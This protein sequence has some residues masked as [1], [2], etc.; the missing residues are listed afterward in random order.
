ME[1]RRELVV[2]GGGPGGDVA[3]LRAARLGLGVTLIDERENLGGTCLNIGCIPS[4]ALLDLSEHYHLAKNGFEKMGIRTGGVEADLGA[5]MRWKQEVVKRSTQGV[6]YLFKKAGIEVVRGRGRLAGPGLVELVGASPAK[7][8]AKHVLLAPGSIP[9]AVP[10]LPTDGRQILTSTEALALEAVPASMLVIG[11]G[12]I[13]LELGSVWARLGTKVTVVEMLDSLLPTL[14]RELGSAL[15]R[16]LK[17]LG[18]TFHLSTTIT[19]LAER[20]DSGV[21]LEANG[22]QGEQVRLEAE[23]V[24][25]AVGRRPNTADLGLAETGVLT[26]PAGRIVIDE[27]WQT[28]VPGIYA[29]GDAVAG[30]MLA[31][32][33]SEEGVAVAETIAG[34]VGHVNYTTL[35][36]VVYTWPEV[37]SVGQSE[38]QLA[39]SGRAYRKGVFPFL[40]SGRARASGDLEGFAKVLSDEQ[41]DEI[42]GVHLLGARCADLIAEAVVA[43][44]Y[45]ASA[46]DLGRIV[47]AHP[48]YSEVLKEASLAAAGMPLHLA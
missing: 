23:L 29:V 15:Q 17:K 18:I 39:A 31:H 27:H 36:S 38:E 19:G 32:K 28:T 46:E 6:S 48:T 24:L 41:S 21:V 11:G 34:K 16:S 35:P 12:V 33:A 42:L 13:G 26:D 7:L 10:V 47:H 20:K 22:A 2:I 3:A 25:V 44:E 40:A 1:E 8:E 5:M 4:K 30:P 45:R 43:M 14:D 37:A 9:T